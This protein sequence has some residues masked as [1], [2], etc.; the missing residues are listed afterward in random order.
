VIMVNYAHNEPMASG[1]RR[2]IQQE[3]CSPIETDIETDNPPSN[4]SL[5]A[6]GYTKSSLAQN[7]SSSTETTQSTEPTQLDSKDKSQATQIAGEAKEQA[8]LTDSSGE[9]QDVKSIAN[10]SSKD[11]GSRDEHNGA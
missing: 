11:K 9:S 8:G 6:D 1:N 5:K 3:E 4:L 10:V 7:E 2:Y